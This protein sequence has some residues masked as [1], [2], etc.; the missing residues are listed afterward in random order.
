MAKDIDAG[1]IEGSRDLYS[2]AF[3]S[4]QPFQMH[5]QNTHTHTHTH[6]LEKFIVIRNENQYM[7]Y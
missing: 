5:A 3:N 6:I 7:S 2:H 4:K 1:I